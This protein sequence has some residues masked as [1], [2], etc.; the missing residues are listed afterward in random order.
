M[1]RA[2]EGGKQSQRRD[3]KG[4]PGREKL[5]SYQKMESTAQ[6]QLFE[7]LERCRKHEG[8]SLQ[9]TYRFFFLSR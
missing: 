4:K 9:Q 8:S 3:V 2:C 7:V 5:K 6:T 1:M